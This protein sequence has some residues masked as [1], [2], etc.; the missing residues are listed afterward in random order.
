LKG[1]AGS[2][3]AAE[4]ALTRAGVDPMARGESL[5]VEEFARIAEALNAA[6]GDA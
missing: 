2:A 5:G 4:Q 1:Y 6:R 3:A